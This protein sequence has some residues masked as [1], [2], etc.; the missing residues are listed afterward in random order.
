MQIHYK[1]DF[2]NSYQIQRINESKNISIKRHMYMN[3]FLIGY[4]KLIGIIGG[5]FDFDKRK[6]AYNCLP[7]Q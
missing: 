1:A 2:H 3:A 5:D 6:K 4:E 7:K